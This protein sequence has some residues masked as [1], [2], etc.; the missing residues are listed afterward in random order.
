VDSLLGPRGTTQSRHWQ[1]TLTFTQLRLEFVDP[2]SGAPLDVGRTFLTMY[3]FDTGGCA[4]PL[5]PHMRDSRSDSRVWT[6]CPEVQRSQ[7]TPRLQ[8]LRLIAQH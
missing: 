4:T 6:R 1:P 7:L 3:D 2:V 5:T 8:Q